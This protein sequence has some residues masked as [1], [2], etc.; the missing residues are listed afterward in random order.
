MTPHE[1]GE[2]DIVEKQFLRTAYNEKADRQQEESR[3][4]G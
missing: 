3:N 4:A 1:W 2:L